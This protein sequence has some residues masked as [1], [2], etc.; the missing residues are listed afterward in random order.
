MNIN[1]NNGLR[2]NEEYL[3]EAE[4]FYLEQMPHGVIM[5]SEIALKALDL[6]REDMP[7]DEQIKAHIETLPY[8]GSCTCEYKEGFEDGA[9]WARAHIIPEPPSTKQEGEEK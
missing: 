1:D 3:L 9:K 5:G 2:P 6:L 7:A 8:Y 4:K